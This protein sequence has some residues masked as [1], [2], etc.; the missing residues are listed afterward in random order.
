MNAKQCI[1][2]SFSILPLLLPPPLQVTS[3]YTPTYKYCI[4]ILITDILPED[5]YKVPLSAPGN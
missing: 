5:E 3:F 1:T 2:N 4:V